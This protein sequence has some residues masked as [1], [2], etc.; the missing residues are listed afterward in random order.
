MSDL[1]QYAFLYMKVYESL[2]EKIISGEYAHNSYL[3]SEHT[4]EK[5][6]EVNRTTVRKALSMLVDEGLV[7]KKPGKGSIIVSPDKKENHIYTFAKRSVAF[8]LPKS[9]KNYDRITQPFY[10][11]LFYTCEQ[12]CSKYDINLIYSTLNKDDDL[13]Q[14]VDGGDYDAIFFVSNVPASILAS[15]VKK[16]IP[17]VLINNYYPDMTSVISD[18][19]TGSYLACKHLIDNGHTNIGL[20]MGPQNYETTR[21]RING[22]ILAMQKAGIPVKKENLLQADW[23]YESGNIAVSNMLKSSSNPPT[24]LLAFNDHLAMGAIYAINAAGKQVP[25]DI[26][27]FGFDNMEQSRYT[28]PPLSTVQ[29]NPKM[30]AKVATEILLDQLSY[31]R[32]PHPVKIIT[33]IKL[34]LRGTTAPNLSKNPIKKEVSSLTDKP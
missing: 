2:K 5:L 27:V 6:F 19:L 16:E 15:A 4:L 13:D 24:A 14:I 34:I 21:E 26:S 33:P 23:D 32:K 29:S 17:A 20:I 18:G 22:F 8:L 9:T 12:E 1:K 31:G 7:K 28:T 10:S 25:E 3:Q 11:S 30:I